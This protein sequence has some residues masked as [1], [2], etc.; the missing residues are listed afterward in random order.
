MRYDNNG[1]FNHEIIN[2]ALEWFKVETGK[3]EINEEDPDF[4]DFILSASM[5]L[6]TGRN[7]IKFLQQ[8]RKMKRDNGN[9]YSQY[10]ARCILKTYSNIVTAIN[11]K[12]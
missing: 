8:A 10:Q 2:D 3:L 4:V 5:D 6:A 1:D 11:N 7:V 9:K 12:D